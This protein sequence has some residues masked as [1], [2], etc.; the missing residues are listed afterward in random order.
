M[1]FRRNFNDNS[2][3]ASEE[4]KI[5][6]YVNVRGILF[7]FFWNDFFFHEAEKRIAKL[8]SLFSVTRFQ[9]LCYFG[10]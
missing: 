2:S 4:K 3:A 9:M 1:L 10:Q 8:V 6:A 7:E 5:I